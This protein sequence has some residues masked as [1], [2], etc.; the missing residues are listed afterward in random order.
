MASSGRQVAVSNLPSGWAQRLVSVIPKL[1][2]AEG[3]ESLEPRSR[4]QATALQPGQQSKTLSPRKFFNFNPE[5]SVLSMG[6]S[7]G[8]VAI[9]WPEAE[10]S[11][12]RF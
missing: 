2:K 3:R 4:L 5:F 7:F 10:P 11:L 6:G 12:L 9:T 8:K 1:W